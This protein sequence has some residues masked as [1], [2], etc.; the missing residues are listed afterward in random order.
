MYADYQAIER[1]TEQAAAKLSEFGRD[2]IYLPSIG[3]GNAA[4]DPGIILPILEK[5]FSDVD[6]VLWLKTNK[7]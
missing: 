3:T 2:R 1:C 5:S 6:A 7:D 4:G